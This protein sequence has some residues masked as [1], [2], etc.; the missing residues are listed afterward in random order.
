M[1]TVRARVARAAAAL[2][3]GVATAVGLVATASPAAASDA[4]DVIREYAMSIDLDDTGVAHVTLDLLVD[5]GS[6]PNHGPYLQWVVQERYDDVLD[7]VYRFRHV[8]VSSQTAPAGVQTQEVVGDGV[9]ST[10]YLVG[11]EDETVVGEHRYHVTFDVEGWV[12]SASF[13]WPDGPLEND[14][15]Y[16]DVISGWQVPIEDV[17]VVVTGPDRPLDAVCHADGACLASLDGGGARITAARV[18]RGDGL[19]IAVAW[20]AGTFGGVEPVLQER[21]SFSRAFAVTPATGGA[22]LLVAAGGGLV[23][24]RRFRRT[25]QDEAYLGL[26]PGLT[27]APGQEAAT[28]RRRRTPVA[29]QFQPPAGLLPGQVGTLVDQRADVRDVTAT[30]I[31]L[32]VREYLRIVHLPDEPAGPDWRL[33]RSTKP[34][35]TLRSYERTLL[36]Q[37]FAGQGVYSVRLSDLRTTFAAALADVRGLLYEEVVDLGWFRGSPPKARQSWALGGVALL[38]AGVLGT[39]LLAMLTNWALVGLPA[40]VLGVVVLALTP[41]APVRTAEGSAVLAQARGFRHYLATAEAEQLRFEEGEDVFSRY[42]PY[43]VAFGLTERWAGLFSRLAAQGQDLPEPAWF[44]GA[45]AAAASFWLAADSLGRD[46]KE[47]TSAASSAFTAPE[48]GTT[49]TTGG[50]GFSSTSSVG[51]GVSGGGG[52]TW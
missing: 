8:R 41:L 37:V 20:P 32:A 10:A 27:P 7:R 3:L 21:W 14:E 30:L 48:P 52:G 13:A 25:A 23:L 16:L 26:T 17:S 51:G 47:F 46:L 12:S 50:S 9:T 49:G 1:S 2:G 6:T 39:A 15:L 31:D 42:L 22:A 38:G 33:D 29:V 44:A 24:W 35:L 18:V 5:F 34:D 19:T 36:H 4:D 40:V 28:G 43:A 45:N 11:D